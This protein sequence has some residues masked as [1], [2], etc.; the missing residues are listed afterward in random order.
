[1]DINQAFLGARPSC[2][3]GM[4]EPV[5]LLVCVRRSALGQ[6]LSASSRGHVEP[7]PSF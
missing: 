7:A 3:R 4:L 1:M 2:H 6:Q 5:S